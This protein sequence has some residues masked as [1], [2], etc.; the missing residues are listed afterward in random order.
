MLRFSGGSILPTPNGQLEYRQSI[1]KEAKLHH[2]SPQT[3]TN[4]PTTTPKQPST[5][6]TNES[7]TTQ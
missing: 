4:G 2:S 5:T 7:I 3:P 6:S 1:L